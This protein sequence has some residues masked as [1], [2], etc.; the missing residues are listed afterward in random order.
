MMTFFLKD[1]EIKK[2]DIIFVKNKFE[3]V[4]CKLIE[5]EYVNAHT[6]MNFICKCGEQSK[7]KWM[8]FVQ[9][10]KY[11]NKCG[12]KKC[13]QY[14]KLCLESVKNYFSL[15]GCKLLESNYVN[16][17]TKMNYICKCGK[18]ALINLNNFKLGKR[19]CKC[20]SEKISKAKRL[21][22]ED[23]KKYFEDNNCIL[24]EKQYFKKSQPMNYICSCG[25][26]S[27]ICY[28]SFQNGG[29]CNYCKKEKIS[30]ANKLIKFE[31]VEKLFLK[32][33]CKI[34]TTKD[35][36]KNSAS[37]IK[38]QC[39][40]GNISSNTYHTFKKGTGKCRKCCM[41]SGSKHPNW[42]SNR[43]E[44]ELNKKIVKKS[45]KMLRS[46]LIATSKIKTYNMRKMLGYSIKELVERLQNHK[47]WNKIKDKNWQIDHIFPI[48]AFIKNKILDLKIINS[49]DNLQPMIDVKNISKGKKYNYKKFKNWLSTKGIS[50]Y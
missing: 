9:G 3:E 50:I 19:C 28:A 38:Y 27:T 34:I 16:S 1:C 39:S 23:I 20:K 18:T 5:N 31:D 12:I 6:Y 22:F 36:Y 41:I 37:L 2:L 11:C 26:I 30:K 21:N 47:N 49:L 45:C 29:R 13:G 4:G 17:S 10:K 42:N 48:N 35:E 33:N 7:V 43:E 46:S 15:Q 44:V 8:K 25:N 40:C 14:K 32:S 24:L